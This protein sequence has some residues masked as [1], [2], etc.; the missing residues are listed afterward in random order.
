MAVRGRV[1]GREGSLV[2]VFN[3]ELTVSEILGVYRGRNSIEAEFRRKTAE[4]T[5]KGLELLP[6]FCFCCGKWSEEVYLPRLRIMIF[7]ENHVNYPA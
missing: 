3:R 6:P 5:S 2:L 7:S 1:T 4:S